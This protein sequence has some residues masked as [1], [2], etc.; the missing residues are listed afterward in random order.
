MRM[1][2]FV[3][4]DVLALGF[5]YIRAERSPTMWPLHCYS[6]LGDFPFQRSEAQSHGP[7]GALPNIVLHHAWCARAMIPAL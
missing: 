4:H 3:D 6:S 5:E 2:R 1:V 7:M